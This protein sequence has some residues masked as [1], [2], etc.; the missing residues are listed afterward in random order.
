MILIV[1]FTHV[2]PPQNGNVRVYC[3]QRTR[4]RDIHR[5]NSTT[6]YD[7]VTLY[8]KLQLGNSNEESVRS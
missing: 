5:D 7:Q 6:F 2:G 3:A 8:I 4:D 1:V